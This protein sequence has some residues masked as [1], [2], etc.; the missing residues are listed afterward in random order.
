MGAT[1]SHYSEECKYRGCRGRKYSQGAG[2]C[3]ERRN[4]TSDWQRCRDRY[5]GRG[6]GFGGNVRDAGID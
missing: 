5:R 2:C 3:D 6:E 4:H 1:G